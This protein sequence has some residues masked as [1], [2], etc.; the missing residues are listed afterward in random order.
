MEQTVTLDHT[1]TTSITTRMEMIM[2][3]YD[4]EPEAVETE[5]PSGVAT[6]SFDAEPADVADDASD[7]E[8]LKRRQGLDRF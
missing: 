8:S 6:D 3:Y 1:E 2:G 5:S 7:L 4:N